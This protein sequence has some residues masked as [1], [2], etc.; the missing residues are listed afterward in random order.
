[1]SAAVATGVGL[2][3]PGVG[4][5]A[6][7]LRGPDVFGAPVDPAALIGKK[8][9]RYKDRATQLAMCAAD[10]ALRDA[11]LLG[12]HGLTVEPASVGVVVS[13]NFGNLDTIS[14]IVQTIVDEDG[15]Q[16]LSPMDTPNAS[17]NVIASTVAIRFGLRGPNLTVCNGATSG[18]DALRW[19]ASLMS[20]GRTDR[21]LVVGV[22]PDNDTVRRLLD[23]R[24]S[25][26]GAVAVV[27]ERA[28]AAA[29]RGVAARARF[30]IAVR[31][32][33]TARCLK[34]LEGAPPAAW[35]GP[36]GGTATP[37][38]VAGVPRHDLSPRWGVASG[39]YGVLQ[40]AAA[41][42]A[43]AAGARGPVHLVSGGAGD[44]ASA[45]LVL[46]EPAR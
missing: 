23:G 35:Y 21:M 6:M 7:L 19:A 17:S 33:G 42:G 36:E 40:C 11:G 4:S 46:S 20:A 43:F 13:S 25:I 29:G 26:D 16:G 1:M 14:K 12:P 2:A 31:T 10:A 28:D 41:I 37:P 3:L 15:T 32:G 39:A 34:L 22:E 24:S 44:D 9:L 27:V 5:P 18:L 30:G 45:G 8:G 38:S